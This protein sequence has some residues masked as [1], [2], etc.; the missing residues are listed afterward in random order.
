MAFQAIRVVDTTKDVPIIPDTYAARLC[1]V[2]QHGDLKKVRQLA[3]RVTPERL[4]DELM[5]RMGA[6]GYTA[7]HEAV[8]NGNAEILQYLLERAVSASVNCRANGGRTPLHVAAT[9]DQRK[10]AE[11][12]LE[13]GADMYCTDENECTPKQAAKGTNSVVKLLHS[14]G[15]IYTPVVCLVNP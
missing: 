12:L 6:Q 9:H 11:I 3:E 13:Y 5:N 2:C 7:L 10:C 15:N 1:T 14:E 8:A 4:R